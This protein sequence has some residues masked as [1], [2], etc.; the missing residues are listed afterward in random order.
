M[1][2]TTS[3]GYTSTGRKNRIPGWTSAHTINLKIE[4]LQK[5]V[6]QLEEDPEEDDPRVGSRERQGKG[7]EFAE[8]F[9][10]M[11]L[12]NEEIA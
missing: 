2:R 4:A 8:A 7:M 5:H 1:S 6:S 12:V 10:V 3:N 9:Q 11:I